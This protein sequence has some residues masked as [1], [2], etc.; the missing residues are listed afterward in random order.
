MSR[1]SFDDLFDIP[2][3]PKVKDYPLVHA[4][5]QE[6]VRVICPTPQGPFIAGGS[7]LQWYQQKPID[8]AD[9]DIFCVDKHQ[10][11]ELKQR[12]HAQA[13]VQEK[14][15]TE[16][17]LTYSYVS[18]SKRSRYWTVQI[19]T[20]RFYDS[21]QDVVNSFDISVCQI[22]TDG[23][24]WA[25]GEH[26]ASDIRNKVLRMN[27]PLQPQAAKR[28]VKYCTYG[29]RPVD[30]LIENIVQNDISTWKFTSMEEYE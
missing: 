11:N 22:G 3:K 12:L 4:D 5:D 17:A 28:L 18:K 24:N 19:I 14:Y 13:T 7:C 25:M 29:Y 10:V 9:I 23:T 26:T 27:Y 20:K 8:Q 30:G 6:P 16:N 21:L 15:H 1:F 2:E